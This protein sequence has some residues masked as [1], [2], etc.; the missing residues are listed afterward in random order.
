M[1]R[2]WRIRPLISNSL[3]ELIFLLFSDPPADP[4]GWQESLFIHISHGTFKS[5]I[6]SRMLSHAENYRVPNQKSMKTIPGTYLFWSQGL[7]VREIN[8]KTQCIHLV[9]K[10]I[11]QDW[12]EN[13][14]PNAKS[15]LNMQLPLGP[16]SEDF[17]LLDLLSLCVDKIL[18]T[19]AHPE[20]C[21]V[22]HIEFKSHVSQNISSIFQCNT[23][24]SQD[25]PLL[26]H[27]PMANRCTCPSF[28]F[29]QLW[30]EHSLLHWQIQCS[31]QIQILLVIQSATI[32]IF[33][34]VKAVPLKTLK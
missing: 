23:Q 7:T 18:A 29:F 9:L 34:I 15:L 10:Y 17:S 20:V 14:V 2:Q 5:T 31:W 27:P 8:N 1:T 19:L 26:D 11:P 13:S 22:Q 3:N 4:E 16:L 30:K 21:Q 28:P 32:C 24:I 12:L 33:I 6:R 25:N